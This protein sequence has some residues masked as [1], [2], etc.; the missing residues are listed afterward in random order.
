MDNCAVV[1]QVELSEDPEKIGVFGMV[2]GG[3]RPFF[4]PAWGATPPFR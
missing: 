3:L 1:P 4:A 2:Q